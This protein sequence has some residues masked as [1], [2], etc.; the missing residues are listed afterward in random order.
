[1]SSNTKRIEHCNPCGT[2][3]PVNS[4]DECDRGHDIDGYNTIDE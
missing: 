3:R 1:M 4:A 2:K